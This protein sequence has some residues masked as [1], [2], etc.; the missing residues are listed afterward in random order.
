MSDSEVGLFDCGRC[1]SYLG[2]CPAYK[3]LNLSLLRFWWHLNSAISKVSVQLL[4]LAENLIAEARRHTC[5]LWW[6]IIET[7][8]IYHYSIKCSIRLLLF[9][10]FP[11]NER[12]GCAFPQRVYWLGLEVLLSVFGWCKYLDFLRRLVNYARLCSLFALELVLL[13]SLDF[14]PN[15]L[16]LCRVEESIVLSRFV[17]LHGY[18]LWLSFLPTILISDQLDIIRRLYC[19]LVVA[20]LGPLGQAG[21]V[22]QGAPSQHSLTVIHVVLFQQTWPVWGRGR[23]KVFREQQMWR[24]LSFSVN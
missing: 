13:V 16:G 20:L 6:N 8:R 5:S 21:I 17:F 23:L 22:L 3:R 1:S 9:Q 14:L 24:H 18:I 19:F 11:H 4:S 7:H 10:R 15:L 12:L 2:D